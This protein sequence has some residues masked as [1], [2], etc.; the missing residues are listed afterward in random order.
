MDDDMNESQHVDV[1]GVDIAGEVHSHIVALHFADLLTTVQ[2]AARDHGYAFVR[3]HTD[4]LP[5]SMLP[6][7]LVN[8]LAWALMLRRETAYAPHDAE[9]ARERAERAM[10]VGLGKL[11]LLNILAALEERG[12]VL[13]TDPVA[14]T[15]LALDRARQ[16]CNGRAPFGFDEPAHAD[17]TSPRASKH[18]RVAPDDSTK[19]AM[20]KSDDPKMM[21][22]PI[23]NTED[24]G[25]VTRTT[26]PG[27]AGADASS[28]RSVGKSTPAARWHHDATEI[29]VN[30]SDDQ[31]LVSGKGWLTTYN[32]RADSYSNR[33]ARLS[34]EPT[35]RSLVA[36]C[37]ETYRV[38]ADSVEAFNRGAV[39][40]ADH[41]SELDAVELIA[42]I[43]RGVKDE[44]GIGTSSPGSG[45]RMFWIGLGCFVFALVL[46]MWPAIAHM[47]QVF[48]SRL[49]FAANVDA[50]SIGW[51]A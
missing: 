34:I 12:I 24:V 5:S 20:N 30:V 17:P 41:L 7:T 4:D 1:S 29:V 46:I 40:V 44:L 11:L 14:Q 22:S 47:G 2:T 42:R 21:Q 36:G 6:D 16:R 51:L 19:S 45:K 23:T 50:A 18:G 39:V 48:G 8:T 3:R 33:V 25:N 27:C 15:T 10:A 43:E 37:A 32:W 26:G 31:V 13:V 38:V 28:G 35:P 9:V 49:G